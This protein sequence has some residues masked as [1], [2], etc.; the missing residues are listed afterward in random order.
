M[1]EMVVAIGVKGDGGDNSDQGHDNDEHDIANGGRILIY[2][3]S[4]KNYYF[5]TFF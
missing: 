4:N 1:V 3:I 5:C 2:Y